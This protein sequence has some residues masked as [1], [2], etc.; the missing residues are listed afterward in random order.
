MRD[1][2]GEIL[3]KSDPRGRDR[4]RAAAGDHSS[5]SLVELVL[6]GGVHRDLRV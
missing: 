4:A 5:T 2:G 6:Q 3:E 1:Y